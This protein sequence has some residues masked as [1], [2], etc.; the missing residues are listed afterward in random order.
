MEEDEDSGFNLR[1]VQ[2]VEEIPHQGLLKQSPPSRCGVRGGNA[3]DLQRMFGFFFLFSFF[4]FEPRILSI[5]AL[6]L[7]PLVISSLP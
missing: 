3:C 1:G 4:F 7:V 2:A 6:G 5:A